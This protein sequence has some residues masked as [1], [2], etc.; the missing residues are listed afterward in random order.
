M[1]Y[2]VVKKSFAPNDG[3]DGKLLVLIGMFVDCLTENSVLPCA[4]RL[5]LTA[6]DST[7]IA[8]PLFEAPHSVGDYFSRHPDQQTSQ[9]TADEEEE[10]NFG[11]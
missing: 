8:E 1:F 2:N 6:S 4:V 3:S 9:S 7:W 11:F 10:P 5:T